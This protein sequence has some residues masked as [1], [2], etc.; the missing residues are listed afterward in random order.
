MSYNPQFVKIATMRALNKVA[1][2]IQSRKK[3]Q[4]KSNS[5]DSSV[6]QEAKDILARSSEA[7]A[8]K[9]VQAA[10]L[11]AHPYT[12]L[13]GKILPAAKKALPMASTAVESA[14]WAA[15]GKNPVTDYDYDKSGIVDALLDATDFT[16]P[17]AMTR[18]G[19]RAVRT[20][21]QAA[22][23]RDE[24]IRSGALDPRSS[25]AIKSQYDALIPPGYRL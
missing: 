18:T 4:N 16:N 11:S 14:Q 15:T 22:K 6:T 1:K 20:Q 10:S 25:S 5:S 19:V 2:P 8:K 3:K 7:G 23:K 12:A 13:G 21:A 24:L 9:G 17:Y